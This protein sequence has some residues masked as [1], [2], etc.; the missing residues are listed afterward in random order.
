MTLYIRL[1][2]ILCLGNQFLNC[3]SDVE[4][5]NKKRTDQCI[6]LLGYASQIRSGLPSDS[7]TEQEREIFER[8]GFSYTC[9]A[10]SGNSP[11]CIEYYFINAE[12][13]EKT[14][15]C[16]NQYKK[17]SSSCSTQNR[18]GTCLV[19]GSEGYEKRLYNLPN[20]SEESALLDCQVQGG[21]FTPKD[22]TD[23]GIPIL[24]A[25]GLVEQ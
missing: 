16:P 5:A 9:S 24:V 19:F 15:L 18:V 2:L 25:C 1:L 20:D 14:D 8:S 12:D 4:K 21:E 13:R 11:S 23:L 10:I 22:G 6:R 17:F 7:R 3:G